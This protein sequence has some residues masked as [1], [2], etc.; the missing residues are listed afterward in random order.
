MTFDGYI[1]CGTPRSGSTLLCGLLAATK[2]AGD[3][4]SFFRR[5]IIDWWAGEWGLPARAAMDAKAFDTAYLKA[6]IDAGKGG[7]PIFGLRLM[8]ENLDELSA[9]LDGLFPSLPSDRARLERAFGRL[10]Y[11]HLSR[12]DKLAQA[13][14]RVK[15]EQTGLWHVAPDGTEIERVAPPSEPRYDFDGIHREVVELESYDAAWNAWFDEQGIEPLRVGY[16]TLS[17]APAATLARICTAL[18]VPPP[19]AGDVRPGVA[20]LADA[21]SADWA[22]RYSLDIAAVR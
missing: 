21:T 7:T 1:I 19:D 9:M 5:Q 11:V 3:P 12:E 10:L 17:A 16:E 13:I 6:A 22:R 18:G 15:A 2:A 14:S 8:R 20:R 4:D